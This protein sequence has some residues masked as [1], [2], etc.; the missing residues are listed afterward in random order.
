MK[1]IFID[2]DGTIADLT[3]RVHHIDNSNPSS[4]KDWEA[5]YRDISKDR[6][7]PSTIGMVKALANSGWFIILITGRDAE[8]RGLTEAWLK[9]HNVPWDVLLMRPIG[10]HTTD[11]EIKRTWLRKMRDG[12]LVFRGVDVPE[13]VL[14]DRKKVIK[15]WRE[16]GLIALQCA[17]GDF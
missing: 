12:E 1:S 4:E 13:I 6:P 3:H 16:E 9:E 5:F 11:V 2:I 14:E 8:R 15:M 10:N 7:I 17:E